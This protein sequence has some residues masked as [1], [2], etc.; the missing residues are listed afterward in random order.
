MSKKHPDLPPNVYPKGRWFYRVTADG[1]RRVWTK[2]TLVRDGMA[3][4]YGKLRDLAAD[5]VAPDRMPALVAAWMAE[6]MPDHADSTQELDR[7]VMGAIATEFAEFRASQVT[8]PQCIDFLKDYRDRPR[9]YNLMRSG[10]LE[11][12][13]YAE[14]K[15]HHGVP[16]RQ[17]GSNP[18]ASIKRMSTPARKRYITDSE[19]RRIKVGALIGNDGLRTQSGPT[20]CAMID[21]AYLAGQRVGDLLDLRWSK[22]AATD[23]AGK[24]IAS[25]VDEEGIFFKPKKIEGSTGAM[26]LVTWTPQLRALVERIKG[27]ARGNVRWVFTKDNGQPYTYS[28]L[29]QAWRRAVARAG[30]ADCHFHD[31]RAKAITD[32]EERHGMQAARRKGAHSTE[33]QTADYVRHMKA[34]KTEATR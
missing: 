12:F 34:Q 10:L 14:G 17:A 16:F 20:V 19:L 18:V 1:K 32:T 27:F 31:L 8:T 26:V 5:G 23:A 13:R 6:I 24:L 25:Y 29:V 11:L 30:V 4:L 3:P 7:W 28:A 9:T 15:E 33:A 2:L 22:R 21:M